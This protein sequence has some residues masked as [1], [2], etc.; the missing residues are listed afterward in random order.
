MMK[1]GRLFVLSGPHN[2]AKLFA[3]DRLNVYEVG[4]ASGSHIKIR[5]DS[6]A[7]NHCRLYKKEETYSVYALSENRPTLVNGESVK[8][9][10]LQHEDRIVI[11]ETELLFELL[12]PENLQNPPD[13]QS[14]QSSAQPPAEPSAQP[15]GQPAEPVPADLT[16]ATEAPSQAP[17]GSPQ[18]TGQDPAGNPES[19]P[20]QAQPAPQAAPTGPAK[21]VVRDGQKNGVIFPLVGKAQ[22]KIGRATNNDIRISDAKVSR[23][24]C[25]IEEVDSAYI[26]IDLESANGTIINGEKVHKTE[27]HNGDFLRLGFTI[28]QFEQA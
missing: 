27:L 8:K 6:L 17:A 11:G 28:L 18:P 21:L 14:L 5:D 7:M 13:L 4:K 19:P 26:I 9:H 3:L 10:I 12:A 25:V 20:Q 16:I 24:H 2:G 1:T 15:A 23:T 22:F